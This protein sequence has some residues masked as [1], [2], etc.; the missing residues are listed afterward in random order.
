MSGHLLVAFQKGFER[1]QFKKKVPYCF[2][3]KHFIDSI[4][5]MYLVKIL[6]VPVSLK[7]K[8]DGRYNRSFAH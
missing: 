7:R 1:P 8:L 2:K 4:L 3:Q 5:L 6:V